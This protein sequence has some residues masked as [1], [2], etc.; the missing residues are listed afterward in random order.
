MK[1]F[2]FSETFSSTQVAQWLTK[3]FLCLLTREELFI[4]S[5]KGLC[6]VQEGSM[7][8]EFV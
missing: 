1:M 2:C 8:L 6:S 3:G 7:F 4:F 5:C